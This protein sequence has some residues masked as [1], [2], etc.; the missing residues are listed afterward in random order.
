M[1]FEK[2]AQP[3]V[4]ARKLQ[5]KVTEEQ[6]RKFLSELVDLLESKEAEIIEA[7]KK[8][9]AKMDPD[10][11][12]YDRLELTPNR[13]SGMREA[14]KYI[15]DL[16]YVPGKELYTHHNS[17][18]VEIRKVMVPFGIIKPGASMLNK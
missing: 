6:R 2:I 14:V 17:S 11:H 13:I 1:N 12:L 5:Y 8:D 3:V 10:N 7:N 4:E 16:Q 9:L 18:G 15:N